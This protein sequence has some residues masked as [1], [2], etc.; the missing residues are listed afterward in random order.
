MDEYTRQCDWETCIQQQKERNVYKNTLHDGGGH[1]LICL[2][3][4]ISLHKMLRFYYF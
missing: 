2:L 1:S 3:L 4:V